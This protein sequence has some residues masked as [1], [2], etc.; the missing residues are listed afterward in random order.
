VKF[1]FLSY[2]TIFTLQKRGDS[3][4]LCEVR[5]AYKDNVTELQAYIL[6]STN[7]TK[8]N[9]SHM[10]TY[11]LYR[12]ADKFLARPGSKQANDSV[13]MAWISFGALTCREKKHFM[14]AR[15]S[16]LLKSRASLTCFRA[17]F[18]PGRAK[19]LSAPR[20]TFSSTNH[21][22]IREKKYPREANFIISEVWIFQV[23]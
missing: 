13:R 22:M 5:R 16:K 8:L 7:N 11:T 12:G 19:D 14:T 21:I 1:N 4:Y 23:R 3:F 9:W 18:F 2:K 15:V 6:G 20:Y 10:E 17:C